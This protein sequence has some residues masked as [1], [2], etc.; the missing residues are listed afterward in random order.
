MA[1]AACPLSCAVPIRA[2]GLMGV[3]CSFVSVRRNDHSP[4]IHPAAERK[5]VR[6]PLAAGR[7]ARLRCSSTSGEA[8]Q[9]GA[10]F[11]GAPE[12]INLKRGPTKDETGSNCARWVVPPGRETPCGARGCAGMY[13]VLARL[14]HVH[15]TALYRTRPLSVVR[16][17]VRHVDHCVDHCTALYR[18]CTARVGNHCAACRVDR[19]PL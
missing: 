2:A 17:S 7:H 3:H 15:G 12:E 16:H 10:R 1:T 9:T 19:R 11:R 14:R 18:D 13:T 5:A 8:A 6:A 4:M